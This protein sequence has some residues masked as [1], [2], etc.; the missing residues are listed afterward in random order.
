MVHPLVVC[1]GLLDKASSLVSL[2]AQYLPNN[3]K[4][5]KTII[6]I[7]TNCDHF[8][9]IITPPPMIHLLMVSMVSANTYFKK[10]PNIAILL[11]YNITGKVLSDPLG[12]LNMSSIIY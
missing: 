11:R 4:W 5:P 8:K 3:Q 7:L 12:P 1:I 10:L 9:L 6:E 2:G